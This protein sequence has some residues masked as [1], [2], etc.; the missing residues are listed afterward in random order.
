MF[1]KSIPIDPPKYGNTIRKENSYDSHS[2]TYYPVAIIGAGESGIAMGC[3]L[4]QA[5][6]FDQFRIFERASGIG[7]TWWSNRYPGVACDVPAVFYSFS[8]CPNYQWKKFHPEGPEIVKYLQGVAEVFQISDKIQLNT[9]VRECRWLESEGVWEIKIVH[10]VPGTG[11]LSERDKQAKATANGRNSVFGLEE[12]I[13]AK[14]LISGVG[15]LVEPKGWPEDIPGKENFEGDIF[16]SARWRY[17]VDLKGKDVIV[18][19][20]GCSA[21]QFVPRLTKEYGA[22]SV[23][24]L[25]RSPPWVVPRLVPPL[26]DEQWEIWGPW[27]TTNIPGL[28]N[29]LRFAVSLLAESDWRFFGNSQYAERE[30][31]KL[32]GQLLEHMRKTVP[33]KYWDM[34]TPNYSVCCKRRI[35]DATWFP[36][37]NDPSLELTTLPLTGIGRDTVTLGPGRTLAANENRK[38]IKEGPNEQRVVPADVI[39]LANGFE[40]LDWFSPLKV[41]GRHGKE[42]NQVFNERGGASMYMG[43]VIDG[44]PNFFT[45]FGP[46]TVTGHT[47]V[48]LCTENTVEMILKCIKPILK[49]EASEVELKYTAMSKWTK[50]IQNALKKTVWSMGGCRSW[51]V[52][53][54]GYNSTCYPY[55]QIKF[56]YHALFPTWSDWNFKYTSKG[57]FMRRLRSVT[58][59]L[60]FAAAIIALYRLK[61]AKKSITDVVNY[62]KAHVRK[63]I[64]RGSGALQLVSTKI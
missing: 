8:F 10:L 13:R 43:S 44:F 23:T 36:G 25:M 28:A 7:G 18:V 57:Q 53:E 32:E 56:G 3:R 11:D 48:I 58:K 19:G 47:S 51:Y 62:L 64:L 49:G 50:D 5:L 1:G 20:T 9:D 22:K 26:G 60:S 59:I 42:L 16:H 31:K 29:F 63:A 2:Y 52:D 54:N 40:T 12:N 41:H 24:Q 6:G 15:E 46:N 37:L 39:I 27:L 61:K 33:Q 17:D 35:F 4:K 34:L 14:V 30:R 21:A 45:I 38:D 55:T